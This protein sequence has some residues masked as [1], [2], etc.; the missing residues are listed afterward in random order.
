MD[1]EHKGGWWV[2]V[3]TSV[4]LRLRTKHAAL[5]AFMAWNLENLSFVS[6]YRNI[7]KKKV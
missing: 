6:F 3:T 7:I 1:T 5:H 4:H 2:D